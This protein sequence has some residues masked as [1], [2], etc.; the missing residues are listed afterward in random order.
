MP[1][2]APRREEGKE[3]LKAALMSVPRRD[4]VSVTVSVPPPA[5]LNQFPHCSF[6]TSVPGR[7][8]TGN[9]IYRNNNVSLLSQQSC[10]RRRDKKER[11][12]A[13]TSAPATRAQAAR[14]GQKECCGKG[15]RSGNE[16]RGVMAR[17]NTT[18]HS[19]CLAATA[20]G[21]PNVPVGSGEFSTSCVFGTRSFREPPGRQAAGA[22]KPCPSAIVRELFGIHRGHLIG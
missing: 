2:P 5:S 17:I 10:A 15:A 22:T 20:D 13:Q 6:P 14:P 16:C 12:A 4:N 7:E 11:S 3:A 9:R 18:S 21:A 19:R 8:L 1:R